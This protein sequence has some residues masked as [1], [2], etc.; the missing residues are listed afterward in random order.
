M[1]NFG[2]QIFDDQGRLRAD[3]SVIMSRRLGFVDVG[4]VD[5]PNW[6]YQIPNINFNGGTP[7]VHCSALAGLVV[8]GGR[9]WVF[10]VPDV[11]VGPN[12]INLSYNSWHFFVPDDTT[13]G[14]CLGGMR[15]HYGV[16][17]K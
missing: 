12:Y 10:T 7:F 17:N 15:V 6:F 4:F 16:Y 1:A 14:V 5:G 8:P 11:N 9:T 3:N 2:W 13:F